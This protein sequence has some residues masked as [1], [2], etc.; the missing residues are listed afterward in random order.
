MYA[1]GFFLVF[2]SFLPRGHPRPTFLFEGLRAAPIWP[3]SAFP[4]TVHALEV[5]A[6]QIRRE[7]LSLLASV[8]EGDSDDDVSRFFL[9]FCEVCYVFPEVLFCFLLVFLV[10]TNF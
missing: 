9:R 4:D 7:L 1:A 3:R 5:A 10:H 6:P 2:P 8:E